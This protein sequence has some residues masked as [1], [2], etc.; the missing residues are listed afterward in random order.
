MLQT[1]DW[2]HTPVKE[3]GLLPPSGFGGISMRVGKKPVIAAVN[4]M[5][6]GG[7]AEMVLNC[8]IVVASEEA[9]LILPDVKVGLTL[10]GGALPRL[11]RAV[12]KQRATLMCLTG[13]PIG[14]QQ[15]LEWGLIS[16]IAKDSV[17][18]ALKIGIEIIQNSPDAILA[19]RD[20]LMMGWG[21]MGVDEAGKSFIN[22]WWPSLRQG[23]NS[24]EGIKA[25][26][27]RRKPK[28]A[29]SKL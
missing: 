18:E 16:V 24:K 8:D 27:E 25:F 1:K 17:D 6:V 22:K 4:G 12:G 7:G 14:A 11:V 9:Q 29:P 5:S 13:R 20:G 10:L 3:Q 21:G 26:L 15:A 2:I 19:T 28:W 23:E